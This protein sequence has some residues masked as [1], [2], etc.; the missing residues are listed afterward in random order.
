MSTYKRLQNLSKRWYGQAKYFDVRIATC[1]F[2]TTV[3]LRKSNGKIKHQ[4]NSY[5]YNLAKQIVRTKYAYVIDRWK[6]RE[7]VKGVI[8]SSC[9]IFVFWWQGFEEA[10]ELVRECEERIQKLNPKHKIVEIDANNWGTFVDIP[11]ELIAKVDHKKITIAQFSDILRFELLKKYGGIW[12]D[13]TCYLTTSLSTDIYAH[14]FYT[15]NHG[16]TWEHP[17]CKG[18][19]AGFFLGSSKNNYLV[20]F[21]SDMFVEYWMHE[22]AMIA[23]L[24]VDILIAIA[25]EELPIAREM[26]D[27]VPSNNPQRER[28]LTLMK[29]SHG[30]G[31]EE[32]IA[33]IS[34]DDTYIHKLT[35][36]LNID[37][38]R[39]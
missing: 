17:I 38:F 32:A 22:E 9:P 34:P 25:Y 18:K 2:L 6:N 16:Q 24:L 13:P 27:K 35:Y 37:K 7:D 3:L 14:E 15:I 21:V 8:D 29:E 20:N 33:T 26:I 10:P 12:I 39:R 1:D 5:Y 36:K 19:W 31:F 28:V 23:Y 11:E 30:R 4:L